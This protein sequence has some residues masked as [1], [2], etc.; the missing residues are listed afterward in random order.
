MNRQPIGLYLHIPFCRGGKCPYCDFYS[1]PFEEDLA[2]A[3]TTALIRAMEDHPFGSLQADTVYFGGGTPTL[4]GE[5]RLDALLE[6]AV[7][8]FGLPRDSEI[9]LE[10]NPESVTRELLQS[11]RLSGFTRVSVGVQSGVDQELTALGRPHTSAQARQAILWAHQAGFAHISA[12]LM[13][14]I[15]GQSEESL[16]QSTSFLTSL[17]VDHI[18]AYLLKIEEGT[19]YHQKRR[20]L[21]LPDEDATADCYLLCAGLLEVAGLPRYEISNF[22][23]PGGQCRHNL[24]YWRCQ[25]YLGLGPAAHSYLQRE[26]SRQGRRCFFAKDLQVFVKADNPYTLLQEEG[27]GGSEEERLMLALRLTEGFDANTL[28]N[29]LGK[30]SL[31]CKARE[32]ASHGLCQIQGETVSL[33]GDGMLVSNGVTLALLEALE[34][35]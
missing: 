33:T 8:S 11:L 19:P 2:D 16:K 28:E 12:D 24:K 35:G 7:R 32:L 4:L 23:R 15:P 17:P 3:Y 30:G 34:V 10:A 26:D 13:L 14:A 18:S 1:L 21:P 25:P 29:P 27:E 22:A 20:E 5:K 31:L 6:A 9:T